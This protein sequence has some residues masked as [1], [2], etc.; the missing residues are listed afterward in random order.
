MRAKATSSLV[1]TLALFF[2]A[3]QANAATPPKPGA[4]CSKVSSTQIYKG[5]KY[6]CIKSGKK[7]IW[8]KGVAVAK[9]QPT[10][11][12]TPTPSPTATPTPSPTPTLTPTPTS[13][14][15]PTITSSPLPKAEDL[16]PGLVRADY[17]GY[18]D[19]NLDWFSNRNPDKISISD[20]VDIQTG[21]GDYFSVQWTGYFIPNESGPWVFSS[22]SDD[23]SGVWIGKSAIGAVPTTIAALSAP[24]IHGPYTVTKQLKLEKDKLY[25][26][27]ILFGDKTNWAQMTLAVKAPSSTLII[28]NLKGLVWHSPISSEL[29]SGIDPDFAVK[30]FSDDQSRGNEELP[31]VTPASEL[32][33]IN[34]CKLRNT[35][36]S[37]GNGRGFPRSPARLQTSG[38]IKGMV[39]F[40]EFNDVLGKN[41]IVRRFDEY[42]TNFRAFYKAQSY[43][44]L[45]IE[46]N[47]FPQYI[48]IYKN[49]SSYG[50]QTHNG[51]NPWPYLK[52][53][54]A[55]ADPVVDFSRIDFVVVIPP[56]ETDQIVYGPAFPLALGDDQ[57]RTNEKV[58]LNATVAGRDSMLNPYRSFWWLSHEVGH[59]F[60]L[61]HQYTWE[62][63]N[64]SSL[65]RAIWDVMDTGDMAPELLAWH[66]FLLDW[67]DESSMRCLN[68]DSRVGTESIHFLAPIESQNAGV[69]S[70]M[71]RLNEYEAIMLEARR[72][73]GF[74][75]ISE[76][77][78][79]VIA[80]KIN[81]RDV[82]STQEVMPI[83][84][85]PFVK[86]STITGN[87]VP[88]DLVVDSTVEIKVLKSTD[89]GYFIKVTMLKP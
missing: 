53:A 35:W 20:Y 1:L 63:V 13:S 51:G 54:L 36:T 14:P 38:T 89:T 42:T 59:L 4:A 7:L 48:R 49:S 83:T 22:T 65:L 44:K 12:P 41:D 23:G 75:R 62:N 55:A 52:D 88:G 34:L 78:E 39:L 37:G 15:T 74:D 61:E 31:K 28:T 6:T 67:L 10:P 21:I 29:N 57:L 27:R 2:T 9:T 33:S 64:Y 82:G 69:K 72:N 50:M 26:L 43:G 46:M 11:T 19:D 86:G 68:R 18:F 5:K 73:L 87:L 84:N 66:R 25:P 30:R 8:N 45:N 76:F 85:L 79:G 40:V 81:V 47:Y 70:V 71:I 16:K 32:D 3:L 60:G 24:G 77:D 80:Y 17:Q 56:V 58:I